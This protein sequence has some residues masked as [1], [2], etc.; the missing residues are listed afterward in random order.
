M[1]VC[2][3]NSKII[4]TL[5]RSNVCR[6]TLTV[7]VTPASYPQHQ[8]PCFKVSVTSLEWK[9]SRSESFGVDDYCY[10]ANR[11][12]VSRGRGW[13]SYLSTSPLACCVTP[14]HLHLCTQMTDEA[15]TGVNPD[16]PVPAV[17]GM[18]TS[19]TMT[20]T[21]RQWRDAYFTR[22]GHQWCRAQFYLNEST[23]VPVTVAR[24]RP[25]QPNSS[26]NV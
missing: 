12:T 20:F 11:P 3:T 18:H 16:P 23:S 8:N 21:K 14:A 22:I 10:P 19:C 9:W 15:L 24:K 1:Y 6:G 7:H 26:Q 4:C 13:R 25:A 5:T 17:C 2:R